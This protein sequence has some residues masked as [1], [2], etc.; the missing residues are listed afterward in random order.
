MDRGREMERLR[1]R[2]EHGRRYESM[3]QTQ[4]WK[5]FE[6]EVGKIIEAMRDQALSKEMLNKPVEHASLVGGY[7]SI[8]SLMNL[9]K[10]SKEVGQKAQARFDQ[11]SKE[12]REED[13]QQRK[14]RRI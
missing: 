1:E 8:K 10:G 12:Q 3:M 5:L 6:E 4:G 2:A 13:A 7:N 14:L 9:V 11:L